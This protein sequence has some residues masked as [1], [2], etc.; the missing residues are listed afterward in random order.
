MA[1]QDKNALIDALQKID[2]DQN[3]KELL[4]SLLPEQ[5]DIAEQILTEA[6]NDA[7]ETIQ[8]IY[9]NPIEFDELTKF[10]D[11]AY[12]NELLKFIRIELKKAKSDPSFANITF[13]ELE[14]LNNTEITGEPTDPNSKFAIILE[15]AKRSME[16]APKL[17]AGKMPDSI[18]LPRDKIT[19]KII[20]KG[21]K[22]NHKT[23]KLAIKVDT[24]PADKKK[25]KPSAPD[26]TVIV[27]L[28]FSKLK[29]EGLLPP[30]FTIKTFYVM[31]FAWE[32]AQANGGYTTATA[33]YN[34]LHS[35]DRINTNSAKVN[36]KGIVEINK[37]LDKL[38]GRIWYDNSIENQF[39]P[40]YEK[41]VLDTDLL[42]FE[43]VT[44]Y[45]NGTLT[46]AAIHPLKEPFLLSNARSR[47]QI[48]TVKREL[49]MIPISHTEENDRINNY[50]LNRISRMK[51]DAKTP[52]KILISSL[53][54]ACEVKETKKDRIKTKLCKLLDHYKANEYIAGY[55]YT[56]NCISI[57]L[58]NNATKAG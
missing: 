1:E 3:S 24:N 50:L 54:D 26:S 45:V 38:A 34:A 15:R 31:L 44:A 4:L 46:D 17:S 52:R 48:T 13:D 9:D 25:R 53:K 23:W 32:L 30:S 12:L 10:S 22:T 16:N 49:L 20:E 56:D 27:L 40:K 18:V 47:G 29:Q 41:V 5:A 33:I 7:V 8:F 28:D 35:R 11:P 55:R 58:D 39:Y 51:N 37:E 36:A 14:V 6:I 21:G 57:K 2:T 42:H 19:Q 43:R